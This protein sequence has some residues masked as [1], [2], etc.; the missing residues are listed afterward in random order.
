MKKLLTLLLVLALVMGTT[1]MV[2]AEETELPLAEETELTLE[3]QIAALE[4]TIS[5]LEAYLL[6]EG[7]TEEELETATS[8]LL[9][10]ETELL[11]LN[12][13]LEEK[14]KLETIASMEAEL[15]EL[16]EA[17]LALED[18]DTSAFTEEELLVHEEALEALNLEYT[19]LSED[20]ALLTQEEEI[21]PVL[22]LED[23]ISALEVQLLDESLTEE[24]KAAVEAEIL[25]LE[26]ELDALMEA[27]EEENQAT[28]TALEEEIDR[29]KEMLD[30]EALSQE[31]I[32]AIMV[33]LEA[34]E[35]EL[36]ALEEASDNPNAERFEMAE[37][38]EISPGK[39]NLLQKLQSASDME[40]FIFED[41]SNK[42]V[43]DIMKEIKNY[44]KA[45]EE[46]E[47]QT[48]E[49]D[50][51]EEKVYFEE[52]KEKSNGKGRG[53]GNGKGNKK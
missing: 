8:N 30:D 21:N 5:E 40:D 41:W 10:S 42:S 44:R 9:E 26:A 53:N 3:D 52:A 34:L 4:Q 12:A 50:D 45:S 19:N 6:T 37:A 51:S 20:Y 1:A 43:K 31:E 17:L 32:D 49:S 7:L 29:L 36:E 25:A 33:E 46:V 23:A 18:V 13:Q 27:I 35:T 47:L 22:E 2:F 16:E 48:E 15:L 28:K 14:I 11:A 38:L 39:M 24:E